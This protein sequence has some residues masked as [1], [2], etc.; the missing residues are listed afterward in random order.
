MDTVVLTPVGA[1]VAGFTDV[2]GVVAGVVDAEA[3]ADVV[4]T[5]LLDALDDWTADDDCTALLLATEVLLSWA[6][7]CGARAARTATAMNAAFIVLLF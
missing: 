3:E 6:S 2:A 1:V 4:T 7:A 5:A